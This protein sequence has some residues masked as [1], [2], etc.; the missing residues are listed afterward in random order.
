MAAIGEQTENE[1]ATR[2][3][4]EVRK[5]EASRQQRRAIYTTLRMWRDKGTNTGP[6]AKVNKL[7]AHLD[8]VSS[9]LFAPDLVRFG[10]HL[11]PA[12][13]EQWLGPAEMARDE[14]RERWRDSGADLEI[15]QLID[16]ALVFNSAVAKVQADPGTGFRVGYIQPWDFAVGREDVPKLDEQDCFCHWYTL[17]IPQIERWLHDNPRQDALVA[18]AAEHK[19]IPT[20]PSGQQG[21]VISGV[22]GLWPNSSITGGFPG[23]PDSMADV[24]SASVLEPCVT[25]VDVW[26]RRLFRRR[27]PLR[28]RSKGE[29]YE[30]WLVTTVIANANEIFAQRRN[31]DLPWV[32]VAPDQALGAEH[33]FVMVTP[34]PLPDYLWGRSELSDLKEMQLWMASQLDDMKDNITKQLDPATFFSGVS[35]SEEA[36]RA[37]NTAGGAYSSPEPGSKMEPRRIPMGEEP[38]KM[39]TLINSYFANQSGVPESL[40][41]PGTVPGGVR[42]TGQFSQV[43][44]IAAGRIRK[45]ALIVEDPVGHIATKAFKI[46]QR[47]ESQHYTLRDGRSFLL[48]QLPSALSLRVDAHSG[49]PIFRMQTENKAVLMKKVGAIGSEDFVE[50]ID[51]PNRDELKDKARRLDQSRA[52]FAQERLQ[53][54][55]QKAEAKTRRK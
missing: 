54:E 2:V 24:M 28:P 51:P 9:Y 34:R 30:D 48:S 12:V 15:C 38:F 14:F 13:R 29:V 45:M 27:D 43:S 41:E 3:Q 16:W 26:E 52:E 39:L 33:P 31:P 1:E 17:S 5:C 21:L 11:P 46:L 19:Q 10:V 47:N 8:T 53:I 6:R 36:G 7:A 42:S 55:Q 40:S 50:L 20:A 23:E 22:S 35:D 32:R 18:L 44:D 49:A 25:F 4:E 37:M